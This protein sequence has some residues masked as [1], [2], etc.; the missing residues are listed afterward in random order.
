MN[1]TSI[2]DYIKKNYPKIV[3]EPVQFGN[4]LSKALAFI[5]TENK[6][7]IGF[8][9]AGGKMCKLIE[10]IDLKDLSNDDFLK[11]I[12]SLPVLKGFTEKDRQRIIKLF[13]KQG[14]LNKENEIK[15][16]DKEDNKKIKQEKEEKVK[17]ISDKEHKEIVMELEKRISELN[18]NLK[19]KRDEYDVFFDTQSNKMVLIE[20]EYQK[21][22]GE[23]KGQYEKALADLEI[24]KGQIVDQNESILS[25]INNYKQEMKSYIE[26]KEMEIKDLQKLYDKSVK[27]R[28]EI[29]KRLV[30]LIENEK[31]RLTDLE[32]N[33][34]I[35][36]ESD[37]K[38]DTKQKEIISLRDKIQTITDE[39]DSL[40]TDLGKSEMKAALLNGFKLRCREKVLKEKDQIIQA[41]RDY[42]SK[43]LLWSEKVKS[44]VNDYKI[45]ILSDLT[46]AE[47]N[48]KQSLIKNDLDEKE[49]KRLGQNISDIENE[50]KQTIS[51]QLTEL[52]SKEETIKRIEQLR[53][54]SQKQIE[55][56]ENQ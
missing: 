21:K 19:T 20:K 56:Q 7:I 36:S 38:L 24:C 50:L 32:K 26:G 12:N 44:N 17:T 39:L 4:V 9:S 29:E 52:S 46:K 27:E 45:K 3:F 31:G 14:E 34:D 15:S 1:T 8:I 2:V 16:E 47:T 41:I 35:I 23:I 25:G 54:E 49:I 11:T 6:L 37:L 5:V 28:E 43:W 42:N 10:P 40:K 55:Q 51:K 30:S 18:L 33:K 22:I 13:T 48:L 53:L